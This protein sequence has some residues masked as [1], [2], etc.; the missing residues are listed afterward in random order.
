MEYRALT[1]LDRM[2]SFIKT[3]P[4]IPELLFAAVLIWSFAF[5]QGWS[6]L[7]AD[8]DTGWHIRNGEQIID[9][10]SVPHSDAFAFGSAGHPWFSWEWMSD[11]LFAALFRKGGLK[12]VSV[13]CGIVIAASVSVLFRHM[14]WRSVGICIALPLALLAVGASSVHYLA[15]PHVIG[16]LFFALAA[17]AIDGERANPGRRIWGL[18]FL[19]L[20]WVN[21]HGSFLAG[22]AMLGL[23]FAES[24]IHFWMK[25][26]PDRS[27]R[28]YLTRPAILLASGTAAT[29]C[30]PYGWHLHAHALEYLRSS[31][32][33]ATVEEFQSPRFRSENMFQYEILLIVG[34]AALPWLMRRREFYPVC[35]I[36]LWAHESLASVRHVPLYC[37]AACPFTA[38]WLQDRWN[39]RVRRCRSGS[40][41]QALNSINL[42]WRPWTGGF[43]VWP[44]ILCIFIGATAGNQFSSEGGVSFPASKFPVKMVDRNLPCLTPDPGVPLRIFSSDQWSDYLIFR[45]YPAVRI[46]FDGRSDFFGP[47]RGKAYLQLMGGQPD[48][49]SILARENVE[50]A[51]IPADWALAGILRGDPHWRMVDKD[52][53]AV[54][55]VRQTTKIALYPNQKLR[56]RR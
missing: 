51:L 48:S 39:R 47:W 20:F 32:I 54:L 2:L 55:F 10:R 7:L 50:T 35:V 40:R 15:R 1:P 30:N 12:A 45:L 46:F 4:R 43:T 24:L 6:A 56:G 49:P 21:C 25:K 17:W 13:F 23:W 53:Q 27:D 37:L 22:L 14:V 36:L 29:F 44:A 5:G 28:R 3:P 8:G 18:P 33:Q 11:V 52:E 9:T 16:L 34:I 19:F 38:S 42:T 26:E 41:F 31:W